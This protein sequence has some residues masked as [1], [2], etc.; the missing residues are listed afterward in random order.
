MPPPPSAASEHPQKP[1]GGRSPR[2]PVGQ[3]AAKPSARRKRAATPAEPVG[4]SDGRGRAKHR[5]IFGDAAVDR[6]YRLARADLAN[7]GYFRLIEQ[8]DAD[9][10]T[11]VVVIAKLWRIDAA[12]DGSLSLFERPSALV[13]WE[14][15]KCLSTWPEIPMFPVR[16]VG[17]LGWWRDLVHR[18][19]G[20]VVN[21]HASGQALEDSAEQRM[22]ASL[23]NRY[24]GSWRF[25]GERG[26]RFVRTGHVL[27]D[28]PM[29]SA[30]K[31][32]RRALWSTIMDRELVSA[33]V[34]MANRAHTLRDYLRCAAHRH[35]ILRVAKERR[36][37]LPLLTC[38]KSSEWDRPDLFARNTWVADAGGKS[39]IEEED[40]QQFDLHGERFRALLSAS[41]HRWLM[42][43]PATVVRTWAVAKNPLVLENIAKANISEKVP[44][45]VWGMLIE[46]STRFQIT[47][48]G[49]CE[50]IQRLY[51]IF[52]LH[53]RNV[54][55]TE[56]YQALKNLGPNAPNPDGPE[57][58]VRG[59]TELIDIVDWLRAEGIA[60]GFPERNST[61]KSLKR[62]SHEWH[63]RTREQ[64]HLS[65]IQTGL[66]LSWRSLIDEVEIDGVKFAALTTTD[67][68]RAESLSQRHC[69]E[70]YDEECDL[71]GYLVFSCEEQ[72]GTRSTIGLHRDQGEWA[73]EQHRGARN[74]PVSMAAAAAGLKLAKRYSAAEKNAADQS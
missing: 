54:W 7:G 22:V 46:S 41:S 70:T 13:D 5:P 72:D 2:R 53:H 30:A 11:K 69:V 66:K 65:T 60:Q 12:P 23:Q 40:F 26:P 1:A 68:L 34:S 38:I 55:L 52:A 48:L 62:R 20:R 67:M 14:P 45:M 31:A 36:N 56:G 10:G 28:G 50:P 71:G 24:A 3:R 16:L 4:Q 19:V 17:N 27:S 43:A 39:P 42:S 49:V 9:D 57:G 47:A 37:V 44:A 73:V 15:M 21:H 74:K 32:L 29:S 6:V 18:A 51:R 58:S 63:E 59:F 33:M 35:A 61:W 25:A 8:S 64:R